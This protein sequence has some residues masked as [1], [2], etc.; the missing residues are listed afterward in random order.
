[1]SS[2]S[3][4]SATAT[5]VKMEVATVERASLGESPLASESNVKPLPVSASPGTAFL[6]DLLT[7]LENILQRPLCM[8]TLAKD[9]VITEDISEGI[10]DI[11]DALTDTFADIQNRFLN[12]EE[13]MHSKVDK[14]A[15][16]IFAAIIRQCAGDM[17][18]LGVP[19]HTNS[20]PEHIK[21]TIA[22]GIEAGIHVVTVTIDACLSAIKATLARFRPLLKTAAKAPSLLPP[23]TDKTYHTLLTSEQVTHICATAL[24]IWYQRITQRIQ[25]AEAWSKVIFHGMRLAPNKMLL[26]FSHDSPDTLIRDALQAICIILNLEPHAASPVLAGAR[27]V[28]LPQGF[29]PV[30]PTVKLFILACLRCH[31][32]SSS[33]LTGEEIM[34]ELHTN[35][36]FTDVYF[37]GI[38]AFTTFAG[39]EDTRERASLIFSIKDLKRDFC[40]RFLIGHDNRGEPS[41][42]V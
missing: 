41:M 39:P 9:P 12:N 34:T 35:P 1:M 14:G 16:A 23:P 18:P 2:S 15:S 21:S 5:D 38:P 24:A 31:P 11:V 29:C 6:R 37:N 27:T 8:V 10:I 36:V 32:V 25:K 4:Q 33:L 40:S 20:V 28:M 19:A 30:L 17:D 13:V 42:S 22:K 3:A 26:T 7:D